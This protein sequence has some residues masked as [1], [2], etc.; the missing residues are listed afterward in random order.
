MKKKDSGD[1][2]EAMKQALILAFDS[3]EQTFYE[4]AQEE[5][6]EKKK[7]KKIGSC[8]ICCVLT[9]EFVIVANAGDSKCIL[10]S[11]ETG[12]TVELNEMFNTNN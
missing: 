7:Y 4:K 11:Q 2:K 5:L 10:V 12:E 1:K 9:K 8:V 3:L 6:M